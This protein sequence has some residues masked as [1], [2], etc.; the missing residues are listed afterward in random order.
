MARPAGA[1]VKKQSSWWLL[2]IDPPE[3]LDAGQRE[4]QPVPRRVHRHV[5]HHRARRGDL[6][7]LR[8]LGRGVEGHDLVGARLVVPDAPVGADRDA[9]GLARVAARAGILAHLTRGGVEPGHPATGAIPGPHPAPWLD[10]E[11][12]R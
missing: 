8:A 5:A 7:R 12:Q 9:V 4:P 1:A 6:D 11:T 2:E 3:L 10:A